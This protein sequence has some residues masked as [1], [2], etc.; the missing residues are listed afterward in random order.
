MDP[1]DFSGNSCLDSTNV[2]VSRCWPQI[3]ETSQSDYNDLY[4][5]ELGKVHKDKSY[6]YFNN[7]NRLVRE[8]PR[9]HTASDEERVTVRCSND[10]LGM[11]HNSEV[12]AP[13]HR[14]LD[15][16]GAG[17]GG[18]RNIS[19]HNQCAIA[20]EKTLADLHGKEAAL[21]F[22]LLFRCE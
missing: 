6:R 8:F 18:T 5:Y 4:K 17:S 14:T 12:L 20:L 13:T 9:A 16:C 19:G 11:G 1:P 3:R 22:Q 21:V 10:Y 15:I 2:T 7:I